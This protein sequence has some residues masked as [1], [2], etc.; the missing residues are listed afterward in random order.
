MINDKIFEIPETSSPKRR[1]EKFDKW[2]PRGP[3]KRTSV[4]RQNFV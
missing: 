1:L 2:R 4:T 3:S